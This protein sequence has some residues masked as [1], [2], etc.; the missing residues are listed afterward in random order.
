MKNIISINKKAS[1][2]YTL[3]DFFICGIQ[4][5]GA[6]IKSIRSNFYSNTDDVTAGSTIT[7]KGT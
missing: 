3:S 5:K 6:E 1:F 4:L 7:Y 2:N